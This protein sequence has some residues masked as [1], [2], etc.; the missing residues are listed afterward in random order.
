MCKCKSLGRR[1]DNKI[2]AFLHLQ[3]IGY[4]PCYTVLWPRTCLTN[5]AWLRVK[6]TKIFSEVD[7]N[8]HGNRRVE[9]WKNHQTS[10]MLA[11][12]FHGGIQVTLADV[13]CNWDLHVKLQTVKYPKSHNDT[14]S[15]NPDFFSILWWLQNFTKFTNQPCKETYLP[16]IQM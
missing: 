5:D 9:L 8:Q 7:P 4:S 12:C 16:R 2:K 15:Q 10:Q 6:H 1:K 11:T 14:T 3:I 13:Q